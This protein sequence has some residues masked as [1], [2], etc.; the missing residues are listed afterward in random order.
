MTDLSRLTKA[1]LIKK[2][3]EDI[4][5]EKADKPFDL[6]DTIYDRSRDF[7]EYEE[8]KRKQAEKTRKFREAMVN[9]KG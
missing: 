2:L 4:E 1:E 6:K 7:P 8:H 5:K 9:F 3:E